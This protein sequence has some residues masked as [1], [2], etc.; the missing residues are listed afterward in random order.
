MIDEIKLSCEKHLIDLINKSNCEI[1][2]K[3]SEKY[4]AF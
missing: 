1:I 4:N 3:Y 2:Y